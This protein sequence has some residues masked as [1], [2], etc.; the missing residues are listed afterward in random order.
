M[1]FQFSDGGRVAAGY[2]G[3]AGDCVVRSVAIATGLPYQQSTTS[4]TSYRP[5]NEWANVSGEQAMRGPEFTNPQ[6]S[7]RWN[8]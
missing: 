4:L 2:K 7:G 5:A 1:K 8:R 3:S 6:S